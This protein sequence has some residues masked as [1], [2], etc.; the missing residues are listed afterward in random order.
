MPLDPPPF[1]VGTSESAGRSLLDDSGQPYPVQ[2]VAAAAFVSGLGPFINVGAAPYNADPTGATDATAAFQAALDLA[3][4]TG[5]LVYV[6]EPSASYRIN[7]NLVP[8]STAHYA[9]SAVLPLVATSPQ[10]LYSGPGAARPANQ[11]LVLNQAAGTPAYNPAWYAQTDLYWDP[12]NVSLAASDANPGTL[13]APV[14]TFAELV[15]RWGSR[16]PTIPGGQTLHV[17]SSQTA[18]VDPVGVFKPN[19]PTGLWKMLG[20][21]TQV[22]GNFAAGAVTTIVRGNPGN[23]FEVAGMPAGAAA[24]QILFDLNANSYCI[25]DSVAAGTATCTSPQ[26]AAGLTT[27]TNQVLTTTFV[28]DQGSWAMNDV[29]GVLLPATIYADEYSP[30]VGEL[31]A[32]PGTQGMSWT[33]GIH[34]GDASG[35]AGNSRTTHRPVGQFVFSLCTWDACVEMLSGAAPL[36]SISG[37]QTADHLASC[38]LIGGGRFSGNLEFWGCAVRYPTADAVFE[39]RCVF[40]HDT[41]L[42][43]GMIFVGPVSAYSVHFPTGSPTIEGGNF[44]MRTDGTNGAIWG[45]ATLFLYAGAHV[46]NRTGGTWANNFLI[47]SKLTSASLTTASAYVPGTGLWTGAIAIS[48]ANIDANGGLVEPVSGAGYSA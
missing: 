41:I 37:P 20:T 10:V 25:I 35:T 30:C 26:A 8:S 21:L 38:R 47:A 46:V 4:K 15:R 11:T 22:G 39:D 44:F 45:A 40:Q 6:P 18:G 42:V 34:F 2:P 3:Y 14:F 17:M 5:Q 28:A 27:P 7:G 48:A 32:V 24:G 36:S 29:C 19:C 33:Q 43:G 13:A 16:S 9:A 1:L 31:S 23:D 12:A